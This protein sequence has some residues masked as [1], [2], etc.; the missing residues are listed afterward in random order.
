M[1]RVGATGRSSLR[2]VARHSS[3]EIA[4]CTDISIIPGWAIID[5]K[6]NVAGRGAGPTFDW[7]RT[8]SGPATAAS[9]DARSDKDSGLSEM[10]SV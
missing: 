4:D 7:W 10:T 8:A 2:S 3:F 9:T 5:G 6:L 1:L